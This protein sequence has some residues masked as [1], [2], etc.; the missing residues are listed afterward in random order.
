M[1][2]ASDSR[3]DFL[4]KAA[5]ATT[6]SVAQ[7]NAQTAKPNIIYLHS[8]DSGR[9]L[10]P[11][12]HAVPTPNLQRL[13]SEGVLFRRAFSA[14]PTCSP[15]R[16]ALLT[17]QCPHR[18]G[19]LGLAHRGFSMNDYSK[20]ILHTLRP[21]GYRSVLAGL[22]HIAADPKTIG[23]DEIL[24]PKST[25]AA[26]VAP[27]AIEFLNRPH[28]TPFFLDVG[29]FETHR[30]Y[31]HPTPADDPRYTLPPAP[32]PDTPETRLDTAAFHSSARNLDRAVGQILD[33][34]DRNGLTGNTLVISTTDHGVAF[35]L[36]K[37][38]L[39]DSGWGVSLIMRGPGG[40]SGGKVIDAL[41][42]QLDIFPT[43]CDLTGIAHPAWLE[44]KSMLPIIRGEAN[45][46][47]DEVFAEVTYHAAYEPK[48][49]VR[50][51]RWKY[52]RRFGDKHTPVLPNCDDGLSKSLWLEY[53][54]KNM[55]LPEESLYDLIFDPNEHN[56]LAV[57]PT[58]KTVLTEM[59]G[60]LDRWMHRTSDPLLEG[61]VPAPHGAQINNPNGVSPKETPD[62]I[63]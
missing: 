38:N 58:S 39:E 54:W 47:N 11:F 17:G 10:Q 15:S 46:I 35:P 61:P 16:S 63:A 51:G 34:L 42:S 4:L 48:R 45:E 8:H 62:R 31:P 3:R 26:S 56:N 6:I 18:N 27:G 12:G 49:A 20:H 23:F 13:A 21:A 53:G 7:T 25:A 30:E 1:P 9:Y 33:A 50:T 57:D 55:Q 41:I 19:M 36:M 40:F 43:L 60:R 5:A 22:Q 52:I 32:I 2:T 28:N 29:F 59:R 44:G 14:A 24:Q 37:C